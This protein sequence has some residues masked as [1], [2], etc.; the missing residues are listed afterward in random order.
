MIRSITR[1]PSCGSEAAV[2][3]HP[4]RVVFNPDGASGTACPHLAV[5]LATLEAYDTTAD[6]ELAYLP[7][8]SG[9]WVWEHGR[10]LRAYCQPQDEPL[11]GL[12]LDLAHGRLE[13]SERALVRRLRHRVQGAGAEDRE[14]ANPGSGCFEFVAGGRKLYAELSG[15]AVYSSRPATFL[16]AVHALIIL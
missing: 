5:L 10:G 3:D 11:F 12:L 1:C 2:D 13:P 14:R 8:Y 9:G 6:D 7:A 16:S 4:P 15:W